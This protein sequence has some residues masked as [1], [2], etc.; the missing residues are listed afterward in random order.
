MWSFL[1]AADLID[2]DPLEADQGLSLIR[3]FLKCWDLPDHILC[4][5][6]HRHDLFRRQTLSRIVL[7]D[8]F[9]RIKDT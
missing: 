8:S 3:K 9:L 5:P 1:P 2:P 7:D 6:I 4:Q